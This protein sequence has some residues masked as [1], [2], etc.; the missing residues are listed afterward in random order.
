MNKIIGKRQFW[1]LSRGRSIGF[2]EGVYKAGWCIQTE[3]VS[4]RETSSNLSHG[5]VAQLSISKL[6]EEHKVLLCKAFDKK[7]PIKID[8]SVELLGSPFQGDMIQG[9]YIH[10]ITILEDEL[11]S[12]KTC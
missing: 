6:P 11:V 9:K 5:S 2:V 10:G 4:F 1:N 8:F 12:V 7:I 3:F